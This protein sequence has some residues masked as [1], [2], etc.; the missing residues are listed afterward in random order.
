MKTKTYFKVLILFFIITF[1]AGCAAKWSDIKSKY[2]DLLKSGINCTY[3]ANSN[4][5]DDLKTVNIKANNNGIT[6]KLNS[7]THTIISPDVKFNGTINYNGR[8]ISISSSAAQSFFDKYES[9]GKCPNYIYL[10]TDAQAGS[11]EFRTEDCTRMSYCSSYINSS[12]GGTSS[13]GSS[14]K[15][16]TNSKCSKECAINC[17]SLEKDKDN[18]SGKTGIELGYYKDG[19]K[20]KKYFLIKKA[21]SSVSSG[22]S[23]KTIT[24]DDGNWPV[25]VDDLVRYEILGESIN[26]IWLDDN[27]IGE[28]KLTTNPSIND[29]TYYIGDINNDSMPG[30]DITDKLSTVKTL[31]TIPFPGADD[32]QTLLGSPN[33]TGSPAY[34][35]VFAFKVV[36]YVAIILLIVLSV[37]EFVT[38]TASSDQESITKAT[39]KTIRRFV[40]CIVIF[41]LPTLL[42]FGLNFLYDRKMEVCGIT[43]TEK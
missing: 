30:T 16:E 11:S 18:S 34:Y 14:N 27:K 20:T 28:I 31:I 22:V 13:S 9:T 4:M 37:I 1:L 35:L 21:D 24:E 2:G 42:N 3:T 33:D 40:L 39:K 10:N 15:C 19:T 41:A 8:N 7:S 5:L 29:S 17:K 43:Q 26:K 25:I 36:R 6:V 38:A 12:S 32:C 23:I